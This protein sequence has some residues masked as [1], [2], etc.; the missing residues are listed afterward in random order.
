MYIHNFKFDLISNMD[1]MHILGTEP[2]AVILSQ[3]NWFRK[4]KLKIY[5]PQKCQNKVKP[6]G[7]V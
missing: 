5:M 2:S 3:T 4:L 6:K 1:H 7:M